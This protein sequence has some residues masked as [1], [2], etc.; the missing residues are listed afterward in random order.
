MTEFIVRKLL[1]SI[2]LWQKICLDPVTAARDALFTSEHWALCVE[3]LLL[4]CRRCP[5]FH[6]T[7]VRGCRKTPRRT[8]AIRLGQLDTAAYPMAALE[9]ARSACLAELAFLVDLLPD[10]E[11]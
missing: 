9:N 2:G 1:K 7:G 11:E 6:A 5:V 4:E 8:A 3:F 10:P